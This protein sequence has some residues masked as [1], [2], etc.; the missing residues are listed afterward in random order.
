MRENY[1]VSLLVLIFLSL[2]LSLLS[3][4]GHDAQ[5]S[6]SV[7]NVGEQIRGYVVVYKR[8]QDRKAIW[9]FKRT[10]QQSQATLT[11]LQPL[12]Y[13]TSWVLCYTA[14]GK[15]FGSNTIY[16]GTIGGTVSTRQ[17]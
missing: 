17:G 15:V 13:Y 9:S 4:S 3:S 1:P 11:P 5:L 14:S 16:F 8:T 2:G 12:T 6:W 10:L 7:S